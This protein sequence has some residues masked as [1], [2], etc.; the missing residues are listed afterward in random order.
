MVSPLELL[1]AKNR[2]ERGSIDVI[3]LSC[4]AILI[5]VLALPL[6]TLS[7]KP[8]VSAVPQGMVEQR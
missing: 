5:A 7:A 3:V 4:V 8:D 2:G 6:V 1:G